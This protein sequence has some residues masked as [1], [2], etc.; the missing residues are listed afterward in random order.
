MCY[1]EK[2]TFVFCLSEERFNHGAARVA[3]IRNQ[4]QNQDPI[5]FRAAYGPIM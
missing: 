5:V 3:A 2:H 4:K 1:S